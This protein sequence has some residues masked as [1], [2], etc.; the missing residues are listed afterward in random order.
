MSLHFRSATASARGSRPAAL[1]LRARNPAGRTPA[2]LGLVAL[3]LALVLLPAACGGP[4]EAQ[5]RGWAPPVLPAQAK[6]TPVADGVGGAV[7][8]LVE[9]ERG[10]LLRVVATRLTR[11]RHELVL[12]QDARRGLVLER[13]GTLTADADGRADLELEL[14]GHTL[15][16]D[17]R[18]LG[19]D[20]ALVG[21][22]SSSLRGAIDKGVE[23]RETGPPPAPPARRRSAATAAPP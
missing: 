9:T 20:L 10:V 21:P 15:T 18:L 11:G 23:L 6:L 8:L 2:G 12:A 14:V 13:L 5:S 3:C 7:A 17:S 22:A 16:A 19:R 4:R 1:K